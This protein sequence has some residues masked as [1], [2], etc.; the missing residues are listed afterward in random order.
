MNEARLNSEM[1]SGAGL[2]L[3]RLNHLPLTSLMANQWSLRLQ[4]NPSRDFAGSFLRSVSEGLLKGVNLNPLVARHWS[5]TVTE[6][7]PSS[8]MFE[9]VGSDSPENNKLRSARSNSWP[10]W[11]MVSMVTTGPCNK[12]LIQWRPHRRSRFVCRSK[13][14]KSP[15]APPYKLRMDELIISIAMDGWMDSRHLGISNKLLFIH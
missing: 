3:L 1:V 8:E 6:K 2:R 12:L 5:M 15:A 14:T 7:N 9:Y 13:Y 10:I 4:M 11:L